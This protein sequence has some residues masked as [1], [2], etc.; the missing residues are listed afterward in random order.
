MTTPPAA[1]TS[2]EQSALAL[3]ARIDA[4]TAEL[5]DALAQ[6]RQGH[7]MPPPADAM[8]SPAAASQQ[9]A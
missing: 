4:L 1:S 2:D 6:F 3:C 9:R 7:G 5:H 8:P